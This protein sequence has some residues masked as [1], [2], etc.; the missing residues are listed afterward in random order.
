VHRSY[1]VVWRGSLGDQTLSPPEGTTLGYR[2]HAGVDEVPSTYL[3]TLGQ[4]VGT[5]SGLSSLRL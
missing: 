4:K 1:A 5:L 2:T 3:S